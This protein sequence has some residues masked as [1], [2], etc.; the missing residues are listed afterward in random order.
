M[1]IKPARPLC[2]LHRNTVTIDPNRD[3]LTS[4]LRC[5]TKTPPA[6]RVTTHLALSFIEFNN[7]KAPLSAAR[8]SCGSET[9]HLHLNCNLL[10]FAGQLDACRS[11]KP[12]Q[13]T[14]GLLCWQS[15]PRPDRQMCGGAQALPGTLQRT[16]LDTTA[17]DI[18]QC[19]AQPMQQAG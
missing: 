11:V 17:I 14:V 3:Q 4:M 16:L 6:A 10:A 7:T 1:G 8:L 9:I 12:C 19:P 5:Q 13:G 15:R 18:H 2:T